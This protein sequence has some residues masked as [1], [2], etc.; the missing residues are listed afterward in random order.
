[1]PETKNR[2]CRPPLLYAPLIVLA[3]I[4]SGCT[5]QSGSKPVNPREMAWEDIVAAADGGS[6]NWWMFGGSEPINNWVRE[7][8][9]P[10]LAEQY[11]ITLNQIPVGGPF[12]FVN[13]VASEKE[14]GNTNDGLVDTMWINGE[15]FRVMKENGL[16]YGPWAL[17]VPTS[18]YIDWEEDTVAFDF[19]YPVNGYEL[20]YGSAQ[21]VMGYDSARVPDPPDSIADLIAW[22]EANPGRFTYPAVTDF[23][24]SA[25]VRQMCYHAI[26]GPA[27]FLG[28]FDQELF[29]ERFPA[30]WELLNEIESS[31]WNNGASYPST[32]NELQQLFASSEIDY[33]MSYNAG[34]LQTRVDSGFYPDTAD[35][36]VFDEG[37][38]ANT[39]Y[40]AIAFNTPDQAASLVAANFLCGPE[41]QLSATETL[42]W[43]TPLKLDRLPAEWRERFEAVPR[44]PKVLPLEVL[45]SR[46]LPELQAPWVRA[47]NEAW[48]ENVLE[49]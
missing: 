18:D 17:D 3:I 4:V 12:E 32:I 49:K 20:A 38:L 37:T 26:G 29:D 39:S 11:N 45:A 24:G 30:C 28:D 2:N 47:I 9:K 21:F 8:V 1:M 23:T 31:L 34:S 19:G 22:I 46:R 7:W 35:T 5:D 41:A 13:Q 14:A 15:S 36:F 16:L 33:E 10:T 48:I 27:D 44:G 6:V 40:I 25:F 42:N 43:Q